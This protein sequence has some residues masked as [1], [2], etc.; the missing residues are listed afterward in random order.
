MVTSILTRVAPPLSDDELSYD[1][2]SIVVPSLQA[3]KENPT[4]ATKI[5]AKTLKMFFIEN[6]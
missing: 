3:K 4:T 5:I 2:G 1:D 6:S